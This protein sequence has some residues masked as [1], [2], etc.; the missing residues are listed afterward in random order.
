MYKEKFKHENLQPLS[1]KEREEV[2]EETHERY[3]SLGFIAKADYGR[4]GH[5]S[6]DLENDYMKGKD[7]YP[8]N[9]PPAFRHLD[10]LN[11]GEGKTKSQVRSATHL[12]FAQGNAQN[13]KECWRCG[14]KG[15]TVRTCP[16]CSKNKNGKPRNHGKH[17]GHGKNDQNRKNKKMTFTQANSKNNSKKPQ[18][19][20]RGLGFV[21]LGEIST[22]N[23]VLMN[24]PIDY[25]QRIDRNRD[26]LNR[27]RDFLYNTSEEYAISQVSIT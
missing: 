4:Y 22:K 3:I 25:S 8:K 24:D 6:A 19:E 26:L 23:V 13:K 12:A 14:M 10:E 1:K 11:S 15:Y 5:I 17:K 20:N 27:H 2:I 16:K 18:S 7:N 9:M 21:Q